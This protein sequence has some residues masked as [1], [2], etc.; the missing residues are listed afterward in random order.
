[1]LIEGIIASKKTDAKKMNRWLT[2]TLIFRQ[3]KEFTLK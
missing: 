3:L 1:M 2:L